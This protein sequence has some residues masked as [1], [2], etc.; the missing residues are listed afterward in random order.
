M[1]ALVVSWS[2]I[3]EII[4][5]DGAARETEKILRD[6]RDTHRNRLMLWREIDR[7]S[8]IGQDQRKLILENRTIS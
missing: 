7:R 2:L 5:N 8:L 6:S 1:V 4:K 3:K